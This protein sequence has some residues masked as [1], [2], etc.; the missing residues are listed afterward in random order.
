VSQEIVEIVVLGAVAMVVIARLYSVLGRRTG[1]ERPIEP[2]T[3]P[4]SPPTVAA[5]PVAPVPSPEAAGGLADLMRA[6]PSFDAA[7]FLA[8]ARKAYEMIVGAFGG[9]DR[10]ALRPLLTPAVLSVYEQA[11]TEREAAGAKGPELVRLKSAD[12]GEVALE[13]ALAHVNV[14]FEA[15]LAEGAHGLRDAKERWTFERDVASRDPNWRLAA[16]AES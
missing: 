12:L 9:G 10:E 16:V 5:P 13:G 6:D 15:E 3:A 7:K 2:R 4:A 14:K 1:S 11:I 8:G